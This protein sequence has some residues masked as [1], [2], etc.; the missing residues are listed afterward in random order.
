MGWYGL[1][2][3]CMAHRD[4]VRRR[5]WEELAGLMSLWEIGGD[6]NVTLFHD[7]RLRGDTHR[8]AVAD[9]ADFVAEQGLM[10]LPL[11]G[12]EYLVQQFG[13]DWSFS[14]VGILLSGSFAEKASS[15]VLRSC[16]HLPF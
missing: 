7:E 16:S 9:F 2:R 8:S 4:H 10:D 1:L 11:A 5:L 3:V 6:F 14:G 13:L 12:G 15:G